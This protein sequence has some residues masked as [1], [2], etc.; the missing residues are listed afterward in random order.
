[1]LGWNAKQKPW[2]HAVFFGCVWER[3][4]LA[5]RH[6]VIP[7]WRADLLAARGVPWQWQCV[8]PSRLEVALTACP[9]GRITTGLL[10]SFLSSLCLSCDHQSSR[11][12]PSGPTCTAL[13]YACALL[14]DCRRWTQLECGVPHAGAAEPWRHPHARHAAAARGPG[15]SAVREGGS[16]GRVGKRRV[17][18]KCVC[19]CCACRDWPRV[20]RAALG[21][22]GLSA[23]GFAVVCTA[24]EVRVQT[25]TCGEMRGKAAMQMARIDTTAGCLASNNELCVIAARSRAFPEVPRGAPSCTLRYCRTPVECCLAA[26]GRV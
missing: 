10:I 8:G 18:R 25:G 7:G 3:C 1:M 2:T 4:L 17:S 26:R 9:H 13:P 21:G 6:G 20:V 12:G 14:H 23:I 15:A 16:E 19:G 5:P 11:R 22:L 24:V